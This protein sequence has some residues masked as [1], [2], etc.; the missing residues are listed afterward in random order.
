MISP[1][2]SEGTNDFVLVG[3]DKKDIQM[4]FDKEA[5][6]IIIADCI[7][8]LKGEL[9]LDVEAGIPYIETVF[10]SP[11]LLT[12]WKAAVRRKV[13][14]LPFVESIVAFD[15]KVIGDMNDSKVTFSMTVTTDNGITEVISD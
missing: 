11:S 10:T 4:S 8:T 14:S 15:A 9:Q 3:R 2:Q 5:Y 1:S 7:R 6:A 12:K 13:L